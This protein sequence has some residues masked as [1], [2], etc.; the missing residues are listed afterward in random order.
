MIGNKL[1]KSLCI[2]V[3]TTIATT[4]VVVP[5]VVAITDNKQPQPEPTPIIYDAFTVVEDGNYRFIYKLSTETSKTAELN[6]DELNQLAGRFLIKQED[7]TFIINDE[8]TDIGQYLSTVSENSENNIYLIKGNYE[9]F[10][11]RQPNSPIYTNFYGFNSYDKLSRLSSI[12]SD[13]PESDLPFPDYGILNYRLTTDNVVINGSYDYSDGLYTSFQVCDYW[14]ANNCYFDGKISVYGESVQFN[15]CVF[16][17]SKI[18]ETV[19]GNLKSDYPVWFYNISNKG[20]HEIT[21]SKVIGS[22]KGIKLYWDGDFPVDIN[23]TLKNVDFECLSQPIEQKAS[24]QADTQNLVGF[25]HVKYDT[26]CNFGNYPGGNYRDDGTHS[27]FIP[28]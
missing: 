22:G 23:V 25:L 13:N 2:A 3:P 27:E 26:D 21:N 4:I 18:K 7:G 11:Y 15:N 8:S 19:G 5:T 12:Q 14:H 17:G 20:P 10:D 1:Y 6:N 16:D 28:I 24:I 9:L